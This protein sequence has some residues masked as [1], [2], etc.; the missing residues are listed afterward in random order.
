[1]VK[2]L[3]GALVKASFSL[4]YVFRDFK[5]LTPDAL[6]NPVLKSPGLSFLT[7]KQ[8]FQSLP[9]AISGLIIKED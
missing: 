5:F 4:K 6:G 2:N 7:K 1:L 3:T 9:T 8:V